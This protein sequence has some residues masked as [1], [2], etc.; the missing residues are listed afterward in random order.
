VLEKCGL[1]V[2]A[3]VPAS[4]KL[5]DE[6]DQNQADVLLVDLDDSFERDQETIDSMLDYLMEECRLP[7]LFNDS[8]ADRISPAEIP[9]EFGK[10]LSLKL[11]TLIEHGSP[12]SFLYFSGRKKAGAK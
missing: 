3:S 7:V 8:S 9:D 12:G 6:L 2:V 10:K 5:L 4:K 11:T 1:Q